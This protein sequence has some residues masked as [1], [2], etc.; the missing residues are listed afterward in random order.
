MELRITTLS[1]NAVSARPR[2]LLGEWGLSVL[3]EADEQ[4]ILLDTGASLSAARNGTLLGVNWSRIDAIVLSH[5]HYDHTGGLRKVLT[6]IKKQVKVIAHPDVFT[7]KYSQVSKDES[8]VY[9]GMP[10]QKA[11]LESLGAEFQLTSEPVW[12]SQNVVTSGEV[13]MTTEYETIDPGL[14]V[15]QVGELVL[16]TVAD[17]QALFIKTEQGLVVIL[18]CAHRGVINTLR[19]AQNVTAMESIHTVIGGTHLIRASEMQLELTIAELKEFGVRRLGVSHCTGMAAAVR[20]AQE[21]GEDF[22]FNN[23]ATVIAI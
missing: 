4:K 3:V 2:G 20:L 10:F 16:D 5:G 19:H 22:F 14:Y 7:A 21:F 1:E 23:T 8:P 15:R 18:G 6:R 11:E 13:P 9:I 12:L 17:D